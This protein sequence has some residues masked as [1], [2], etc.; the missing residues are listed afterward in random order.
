VSK[1]QCI[2]ENHALRELNSWK[3]GG[4]ADFFCMPENLE[5]LRECYLWAQE[6]S[7]P[8]T[9]LGDGTNVLISD[10]GVEGLVI[11]MRRYVGAKIID[12]SDRLV[13]EC[14]AGTSKAEL[15]KRFLKYKLPPAL[16]LAGLPGDIG[17]GV[18][19]N[20]GVSEDVEP[21][22]FCEVVDSIEVLKPDGAVTTYRNQEIQWSYR[23]S[24]G[25]QPGVVVSA[26]LSW[27]NRPDESVLKQ[28]KQATRQRLMK[29]PLDRPSC[30]S[31]FKN[32]VGN[33]AGA[34][35]DSSGLKGFRV[36]GAEV[37]QK[38]AN[39]IVTDESATSSDVFEV[40]RHVQAE[41]LKRHK[42]SLT[43]EVKMLGRWKS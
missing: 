39:F 37:S 17:G 4:S 1:P 26:K 10:D 25:W 5:E 6:K 18:V 27:P 13:I 9:I 14:L 33:K 11:C 38:H 16:F 24:E 3:V 40:I 12:D 42:V 8:V 21:R 22:E 19:M 7:L 20:A 41:V 23:K 28:I 32:P 43:T 30:G 2:H 36:G 15:L 34:L 35:I 29:Q 31:T